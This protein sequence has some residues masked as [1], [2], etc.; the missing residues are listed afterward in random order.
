MTVRRG[1]SCRTTL[2]TDQLWGLLGAKGL[3]SSH[4]GS[5]A[6]PG[7]P[8]PRNRSWHGNVLQVWGATPLACIEHPS[9]P[10]GIASVPALAGQLG[11]H[12]E[13]PGRAWTRSQLL[14]NGVSDQKV[15]D[16][17]C[18]AHVTSCDLSELFIWGGSFCYCW[19]FSHRVWHKSRTENEVGYPRLLTH[20]AKAAC[21]VLKW[22]C[23]ALAFLYFLAIVDLYQILKAI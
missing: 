15:T 18:K 19:Y 21:N 13:L 23:Q 1:L 9:L 5:A 14:G 20:F 4:T 10:Q 2:T 8:Q 17:L 11:G 6:T 22:E 16:I 3:G 7:S 12:R